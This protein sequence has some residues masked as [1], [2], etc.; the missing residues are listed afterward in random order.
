MLIEMLES[1]AIT[2]GTTL[3]VGCGTATNAIYLA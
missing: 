3:E 2:P 1:R